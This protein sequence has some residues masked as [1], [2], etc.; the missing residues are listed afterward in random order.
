MLWTNQYNDNSKNI[1]KEI[2]LGSLPKG[3]YFI[4]ADFGDSSEMKKLIVE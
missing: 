4:K 2:D 3:S 1:S